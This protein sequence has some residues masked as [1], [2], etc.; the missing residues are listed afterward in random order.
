MKNEG[1]LR[2][3]YTNIWLSR[4]FGKKRN[5]EWSILL[6]GFIII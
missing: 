2:A 5:M 4:R 1:A 3:E 6:I